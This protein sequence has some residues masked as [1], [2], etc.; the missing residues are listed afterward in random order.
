MSDQN[1]RW[2]KPPTRA[3][4]ATIYIRALDDRVGMVLARWWPRIETD[5]KHNAPWTDRT[6]NAR[7]T[8]AAFGYKKSP[9]TWA[10]VLRHWMDYGKWL[11]LCNGGKFAIV[12]PTLQ[13]YYGPVWD[14][15]RQVVP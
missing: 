1:F 6:S 11:E 3:F 7:Q 9:I 4:S 10:L 8:L 5:A 2:T 14:D 12:L 15:V 13:Q